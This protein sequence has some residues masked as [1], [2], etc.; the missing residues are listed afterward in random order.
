MISVAFALVFGIGCGLGGLGQVEI[1]SLFD[2]ASG[3][4]Q[5]GDAIQAISIL[6]TVLVKAENPSSQYARA[7]KGKGQCFRLLG[8]YS[9]AEMLFIACKKMWETSLDTTQS[10]YTD[11]LNDLGVLYNEMGKYEYADDN[12][13]KC[14]KI[15]EKKFGK[16][17]PL[18]AVA[19][20][21]F[22]NNCLDMGQYDNAE[23]YYKEGII[24][25]DSLFGKGSKESSRVLLGLSA[26]YFSM[27]DYEKAEDVLQNHLKVLQNMNMRASPEYAEGLQ[28]L[29]SLYVKLGRWKEAETLFLECKEIKGKRFGKGHLDYAHVINNLASL[30]KNIG[31]FTEAEGLFL[32]CKKI[33]EEAIG[34]DNPD[35]AQVLDNLASLY[36][37]IGCYAEAETLFIESKTIRE[38]VI[39]ENHLDY[40]QVLNN[41]AN[42]LDKMDRDTEAISFNLQAK[43]IF[44]KNGN[45]HSLHYAQVLNNLAL[46]Y[47]KAKLY[48]KSDSLFHQAASILRAQLVRAAKSSSEKEMNDFIKIFEEEV[49]SYFSCSQ[50][51]VDFN[52]ELSD[53]AF[54]NA[55]FYKGFLLQAATAVKNRALA[56][57]LT[58]KVW[59]R[60]GAFHHR[61]AAEYTKPIMGRDSANITY[62]ELQANDLEKELARRVAGFGD[63]FKPVS[64]QDVQVC[65]QPNEAAIEFVQFK[66]VFP[67]PTDSTMYAA[68][69][70]RPGWE[71]PRFVPLFEEKE[72]VQWFDCDGLDRSE[73]TSLIYPK[74]RDS[75]LYSLLFQPLEPHLAGVKTIFFSPSGQLHLLNFGAISIGRDSILSQKYRLIRVGSTR[76]LM[77]RDT[78]IADPPQPLAI[79]FGGV[80]YDTNTVAIRAANVKLDKLTVFRTLNA[81][82]LPFSFTDSTLRAGTFNYLQGT[83]EEV[84]NIRPLIQNRGIAVHAFIGFEATE[85]AF[86]RIGLAAPP[87]R[88]LHLA[89]HGFFFPDPEN[90]DE[91]GG[92]RNNEP[93][94]KIS[95]HP[96]IRSGLV[97]AGGNHAWKTGE[98]A[99]PDLEDGILTAYEISQANLRGTELVVL[100]ACQTGLG[101]LHINEGVYGLQ[102][103]FKIAGARFLVMS[104]WEVPD[105]TTQEFM[106]LFYQKW[107]SENLLL[108]DAFRA[109]QVAMRKKYPGQPLN[110]A[111]WVL[112]E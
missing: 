21:N 11:I 52:Q 24:I 28:N 49:N 47:E 105:G 56:D 88:I 10:G 17:H 87:P 80:Q 91:E 111:G 31:N 34:T 82:E 5:N 44:E 15:L 3:F 67:K 65:L 69:V 84:E 110:W 4:L 35:Y 97:L 57:T 99:S 12:Y 9:K 40:A 103:A 59:Q 85:E 108:P 26:S 53:I 1:D 106:T 14:L 43:S 46:S 37:R 89:T 20:N 64:W 62:L 27:G 19:L 18:Y 45:D 32:E 58:A 81:T 76:Q 51:R 25:R 60:R 78:E 38:K 30:Y 55:L 68:L 75:P 61:L 98:P 16:F 36:T 23:Q 70:L 7:L 71:Q 79:L 33:I 112:V 54:D 93:A 92:L 83:A 95:G 74:S 90:R 107:L 104:L 50:T 109:T 77:T 101:D 94:F 63:A 22:S 48:E 13:R 41:F 2:Q 42:L 8:D 100:S 6:D 29:G 39:G 86:K 66:K 96:M 72:L 102:R 73:C